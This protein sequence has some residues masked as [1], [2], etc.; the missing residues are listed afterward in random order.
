MRTDLS[1]HL[2]TIP[3][4]ELGRLS[5]EDLTQPV[6]DLYEIV[7]PFKRYETTSRKDADNFSKAVA[8][9]VLILGT[10]SHEVRLTKTYDV[11][12]DPVRIKRL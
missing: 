8:G 1:K 7:T 6:Y 9:T 10:V 2:S 12:F 3:D 5:E 4:I 11:R